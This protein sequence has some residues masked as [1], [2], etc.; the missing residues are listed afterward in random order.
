MHTRQPHFK[1]IKCLPVF[2]FASVCDGDGLLWWICSPAPHP[3]RYRSLTFP[4]S[5]TSPHPQSHR[6]WLRL[7]LVRSFDFD[8]QID[9]SRTVTPAKRQTVS[10][11]HS[12]AHV[13][14]QIPILYDNGLCSLARIILR[15]PHRK[16]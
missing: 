15:W 14:V 16:F 2:A 12:L 7:R 13:R 4:A 8:V 6:L 3:P 11:S 10:R 9:H 1:Y 5:F